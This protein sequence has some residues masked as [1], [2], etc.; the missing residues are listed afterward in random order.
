MPVIILSSNSSLSLSIPLYHYE[1][2]ELDGANSWE[3]FWYVTLRGLRPTLVFTT[4]TS[5]F[6]YCGI[7]K[8]F[9]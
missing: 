2:A 7:L 4:V 9:M 1:V 5:A 6:L 3:Q 8:L